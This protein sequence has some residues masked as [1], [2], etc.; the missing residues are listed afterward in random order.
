MER[1]SARGYVLFI[2][3]RSLRTLTS[4]W[5]PVPPA[6]PLL[7]ARPLSCRWSSAGTAT[8]ATS[9]TSSALPPACR[10]ECCGLGLPGGALLRP[11][12]SLHLHGKAPGEGGLPEEEGR[13]RGEEWRVH[14]P[15]GCRTLAV[16][17]TA[18]SQPANTA[19]PTRREPLGGVGQPV[20]LRVCFFF[21]LFI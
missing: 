8:P 6:P 20:P 19:V 12:L 9:W 14:G 5:M 2:F 17:A 7:T 21:H 16:S 15:T 18:G 3:E 11:R 13:E 10:G 4:A 1:S